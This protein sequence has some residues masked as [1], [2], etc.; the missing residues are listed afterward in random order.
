MAVDYSKY[1]GK[2]VDEIERPTTGPAG[3]YF[4]TYQSFKGAERYYDKENPKV[5]TPVVELT[6]KI[7]GP[8]EDAIAEDADSA[9][10][11][12]GRLA[13]KDYT[14]TD[15]GGMFSLR[16]FGEETCGVDGKGLELG[17]LLDAA[18]GSAVLLF[19]QP[20]AG[21]EEGQFYFNVSKVLKVG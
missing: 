15:D 11:M 13:T 6:F 4:A 17:D 10:K 2:K 20:R 12:V 1:L 5:G 21:K 3:H 8:D 16:R 7:T 19:N 18:K 9:E 14:L